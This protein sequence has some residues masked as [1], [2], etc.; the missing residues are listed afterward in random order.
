MVVS[1]AKHKPINLTGKTDIG[2]AAAIL[3]AV[4]LMISNDMGLAHIAPAVGTQTIAIFGPTNPETTRA[5]S[6][7][8]EVIRKPVECSPCMLR[9][10]PIDHRCMNWVTVDEVFEAAKLRLIPDEDDLYEET[11][12]IS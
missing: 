10:C 1:E 5:F 8:S 2:E 12:S 11:G 7:L 6:P 4:D 3:S 9:E